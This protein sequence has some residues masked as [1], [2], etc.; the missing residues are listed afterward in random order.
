MVY[1]Y[2]CVARIIYQTIL[3]LMVQIHTRELN[4]FCC[5]WFP[6]PSKIMELDPYE[7]PDANKNLDYF[8]SW[9]FMK[10][11]LLHNDDHR[12]LSGETYPNKFREDS[13]AFD[14]N[15]VI[16]EIYHATRHHC[17]VISQPLVHIWRPQNVS[18]RFAAWW[19]ETKEY[20][21]RC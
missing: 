18:K 1:A 6:M 15:D 17:G 5:R 7:H 13:K 14:L 8:C 2:S 11:N 16:P 3:S 12:T 20:G 21:V 4:S 10:K 19:A 9:Q